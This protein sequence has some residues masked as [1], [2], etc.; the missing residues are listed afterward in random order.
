MDKSALW[1][2]YQDHRMTSTSP[3]SNSSKNS[4]NN[5]NPAVYGDKNSPSQPRQFKNANTGDNNLTLGHDSVAKI[6]KGGLKNNAIRLDNGQYQD[7]QVQGSAGNNIAPT[8]AGNRQSLAQINFLFNPARQDLIG[9]ILNNY[10][11]YN[12]QIAA[13]NSNGNPLSNTNQNDSSHTDSAPK[14]QLVDATYPSYYL[15]HQDPSINGQPNIGSDGIR[16]RGDSFFLPPPI[17]SQIRLN[18][19]DYENNPNQRQSNS[20]RSNSIFSSLI[21]IPGSGNNSVSDAS[22]GDLQR[23][24]NANGVNVGNNNNN[25]ISAG[26]NKT[27]LNQ[28][29]ITTSNGQG[30]SFL[31]PLAEFEESLGNFLALQQDPKGSLL[32]VK[33]KRGSVDYPISNS[34]W[35]GLNN[36]FAGS[37]SGMPLSGS[38]SGILAGIANGSIDFSNMNEEKR[39]DSILKIIN[40]QQNTQPQ[41]SLEGNTNVPNTK[42]REDIFDTKTSKPGYNKVYNEKT[43][44]YNDNNLKVK[45]EHVS[46]SSSMSSTSST[47]Y[48]DEPQSPKTSPSS[49]HANLNQTSLPQNFNQIQKQAYPTLDQQ[50][51]VTPQVRQQYDYGQGRTN[52]V[53]GFPPDGIKNQ[54]IF[55]QNNL[56]NYQPMQQPQQPQ[57][58]PQQQ[59]L[60]QQQQYYTQLQNYQ[61]QQNQPLQQQY[62]P[63]QVV[64]S[65][66]TSTEQNEPNEHEKD[67]VPAQQ[68]VKAED[69]RPLLGATK[70]DQLMLV[71][72]AREKG[73]NNPIP[74]GPDGSILA[75]PEIKQENGVIP[76]PINLVGGVDKPQKDKLDGDMFEHEDDSS[77]SKKKK[78]KNKQCPYC[79]KYFTQ[80][81]HLEVHVRSHIGY[82][83]FECSYCHKRFTQ[84]GNLRTHLRLHTG[85]KPFTCDVCKRSFS[86][87]GNLAAHKLTHENLKPYECKLDNCDKSFTQLGN[88]KSHQN[89]FHLSTLNELTHKLAELRREEIDSLPKDEK[90]LLNYFKDLYKNSNKGILGRGKRIKPISESNDSKIEPSW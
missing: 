90:D 87:K 60:Q 68:F 37:I 82:K 67:L 76:Q 7:T 16:P 51:Y 19:S 17:N 85:E 64:P 11:T 61:P 36:G 28:P 3:T 42:L 24:N 53:G 57:P 79:F 40:D 84:G 33:S 52:A 62:Q 66:T 54:G 32:G 21:Q 56:P 35:D 9:S 89:R 44:N 18:S 72:Q 30:G 75:S 73:V 13:P 2:T 25:D 27:K 83:P 26:G 88:L 34:F 70:I 5:S 65:G 1:S 50:S 31:I 39:R 20:S 74:Q 48:N 63:G 46:P 29:I 49:Y 14:S 8:N 6:D 15:N 41:R 69:G 10:L 47:R 55:N 80:S 23:A 81:T 86:R 58:Q 38:I 22:H 43:P 71:I 59:Q 78:A 4:G 45:G 77:G 12:N